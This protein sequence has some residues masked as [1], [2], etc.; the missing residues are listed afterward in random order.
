[1]TTPNESD[2]EKLLDKMLGQN[3]V[4]TDEGTLF[5][6]EIAA[7]ILANYIPKPRVD[8]GSEHQVIDGKHDIEYCWCMRIPAEAVRQLNSNYI[9][10][11]DVVKAI[12][13]KKNTW[14][15]SDKEP[16][17]SSYELIAKANGYNQC[18]GDIKRNLGEV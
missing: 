2:L 13:E 7:Q 1:M 14:D 9:S 5:T 18:I 4:G 10:R 16:E 15:F 6:S 3:Y 8:K 11:A 12:P 17:L